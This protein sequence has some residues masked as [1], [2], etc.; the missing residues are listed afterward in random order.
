MDGVKRSVQES[1]RTIKHLP[2]SNI[3]CKAREYLMM[4]VVHVAVC[5]IVPSL[6]GVSFNGCFKLQNFRSIEMFS[7]GTKQTHGQVPTQT[8]IIAA[9]VV[10]CST[11]VDPISIFQIYAFPSWY[12]GDCCGSNVS[13]RNSIVTIY[14]QICCIL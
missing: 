6:S 13:K 9:E 1:N 2:F 10:S 14:F 3:L 4:L 12:N 5:G 7:N 8:G 11:T